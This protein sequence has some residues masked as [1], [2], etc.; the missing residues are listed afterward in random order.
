MWERY[1]RGDRSDEVLKA[2]HNRKS[3]KIDAIMHGRDEDLFRITKGKMV[4]PE[5]AEIYPSIRCALC[6]EKVM[7]PRARIK[8][9]KIVCIP[10]Q[11]SK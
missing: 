8:D 7:E 11:G 4:L 6:G 5:E 2:V 9:G 10:C 1:M 3:R